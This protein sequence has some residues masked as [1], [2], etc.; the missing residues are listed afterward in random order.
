MNRI[1]IAAFKVFVTVRYEVTNAI[2]SQREQTGCR[3]STVRRVAADPLAGG[4]F[5]SFSC[6]NL[7]RRNLPSWPSLSP[8]YLMM[9]KVWSGCALRLAFLSRLAN[10]RRYRQWRIRKAGHRRL[11]RLN[12][13][14]HVD[15]RRDHLQ[16]SR[17]GLPPI[18]SVFLRLPETHHQNE[19]RFFHGTQNDHARE[20]SLLF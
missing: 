11:I 7:F 6:L 9:L 16:N 15:Q 18:S 13:R 20:S 5:G 4:W 3:I 10:R 12:P 8:W 19:A 17:R 14:A 2:K 1:A